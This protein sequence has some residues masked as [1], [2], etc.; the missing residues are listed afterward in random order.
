MKKRLKLVVSF[1]V[2][3]GVLLGVG[4]YFKDKAE[5]GNKTIKIEIIS[6]RD[7]YNE[8]F[9]YKT[10]LDNLGELLKEKK[11]IGYE[12]SSYGMYI[13]EVKGMKEDQSNQY[14]WA[15]L[16]NQESALSGANEIILKDQNVYT[17]E[18]KQGY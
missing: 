7:N 12:D 15:I 4:V 16:V 14:W 2:V 6:S 9:E 18:L 5:V 1:V 17:L 8:I 10:D 13:K 11:L 3:I